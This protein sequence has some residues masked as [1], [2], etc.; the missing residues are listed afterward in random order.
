MNICWE[1]VCNQWAWMGT[2]TVR[3]GK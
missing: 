2:Y 1:Y 3:A